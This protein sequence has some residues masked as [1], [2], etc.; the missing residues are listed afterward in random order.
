MEMKTTML[1][2]SSLKVKLGKHTIFGNG[3]GSTLCLAFVKL[4]S[5]AWFEMYVKP[6]HPEVATMGMRVFFQVIFVTVSSC[7]RS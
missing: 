1:I 2:S 7:E 6:L 4:Q 5:E 3:C